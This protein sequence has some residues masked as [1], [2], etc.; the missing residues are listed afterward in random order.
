M[1]VLKKQVIINRL[2]AGGETS[3][4]QNTDYGRIGNVKFTG[5]EKMMDQIKFDWGGITMRSKEAK[6]RVKIN[7]MLKEAG[8]RFF[9]DENGS[10]NVSVEANVKMTRSQIDGMGENFE[11]S[12]N[13]YVDFLLLDENNRPFI[14]LEAKSEEID[15][16]VGKE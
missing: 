3:R 1:I 10:A 13:G 16:L 4:K 2:F 6:A 11:K 9:D 5:Y 7:D 8:W 12:V 15:P 14:V